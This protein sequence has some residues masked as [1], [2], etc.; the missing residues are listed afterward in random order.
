MAFAR[1]GDVSTRLVDVVQQGQRSA[2]LA[3][4]RLCN[5]AAQV[6]IFQRVMVH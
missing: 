4:E 3:I 5:S 1:L 2:S 6:R